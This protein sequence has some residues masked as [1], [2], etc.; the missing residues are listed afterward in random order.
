MELMLDLLLKNTPRRGRTQMKRKQ[1]DK[2][3]ENINL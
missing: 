3:I 2:V 1:G